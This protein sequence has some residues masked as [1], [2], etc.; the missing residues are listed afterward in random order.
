MTEHTEVNTDIE[1]PPAQARVRSKKKFFSFKKLIITLIILT[2]LIVGGWGIIFSYFAYTNR[3]PI[4][5]VTVQGAY[6]YVETSDIQSTLEPFIV[7]K[8]LYAFNERSAERALEKL[9]GVKKATIWRFPPARIQVEIREFA[10]LARLENGNLVANDGSIFQTSN[11]PSS[12]NLPVLKGNP[13]YTKQMIEMLQSLEPI[14]QTIDTKVTG[15]GL[16]DNGDWSVQ[17]DNQT[18]IMLGKNDLQNRVI[19]FLNAYPTLL[20]TAAAGASLNYVDLR[21]MNGFTVIWNTVTPPS[22]SIG[23]APVAAA[24]PDAPS[25]GPVSVAVASS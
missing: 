8:G 18:W 17:L 19:N 3:F 9:P 22:P 7:G 10:A 20:Q 24:N 12:A 5:V 14:F 16:A 11:T 4:E 2:L 13:R 6:Q 1:T 15:L 25:S 21:Y 23:G